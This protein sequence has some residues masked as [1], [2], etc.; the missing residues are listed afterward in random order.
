VGD[1]ELPP[2][3]SLLVHIDLIGPLPT[4]EGYTYCLTAVDRFTRWPKAISITNI[5]AET[6]ARALLGGLDIRLLVPTDRYHRP[7]TTV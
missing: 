1:F 3:R 2:A 5:T 6:V 4:S 7:G